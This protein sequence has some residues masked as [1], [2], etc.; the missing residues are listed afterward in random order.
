MKREILCKECRNSLLGKISAYHGEYMNSVLG[1]LKLNGLVCDH[2]SIE[3]FKGDNVS[4][5]SI[6]SGSNSYSQWENLYI[7]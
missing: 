7:E 1:K 4:C 6:W 3:L 2:C 5:V